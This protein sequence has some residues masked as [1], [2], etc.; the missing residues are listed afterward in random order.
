MTAAMRMVTGGTAELPDGVW[1]RSKALLE[2]DEAEFGPSGVAASPPSVSGSG[3]ARDGG[4]WNANN[5]AGRSLQSQWGKIKEGIEG[6]EDRRTHARDFKQASYVVQI[7]PPMPPRGQ[8]RKGVGGG[9]MRVVLNA[10]PMTTMAHLRERTMEP[11]HH[12]NRAATAMAPRNV[13]SP[14]PPPTHRWPTSFA[15]EGMRLGN[16]VILR[17]CQQQQ[18]QW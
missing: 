12:C 17:Q 15:G 3:S 8:R 5:E 11:E 4:S 1:E 13:S 6:G 14:P 7:A 10:E 9:S 18:Q 16:A 2:R